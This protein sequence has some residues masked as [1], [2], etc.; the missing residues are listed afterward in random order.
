MTDGEVV[1]AHHSALVGHWKDAVGY[2]G[3]FGVSLIIVVAGRGCVADLR[4]GLK[5]FKW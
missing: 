5:G 3:C 4:L 1:V 2:W